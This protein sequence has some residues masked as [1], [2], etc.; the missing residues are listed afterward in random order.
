MQRAADLRSPGAG[1]RARAAARSA[2]DVHVALVRPGAAE[3]AACGTAALRGRPT[4]ASASGACSATR[5]SI[6]ARRVERDRRDRRARRVPTRAAAEVE[7]R[8]AGRDAC[9]ERGERRRDRPAPVHEPVVGA[10][11]VHID[12]AAVH[13]REEWQTWRFRG[14]D[15]RSSTTSRPRSRGSSRER[16]ARARSRCRAA[17]P[18][19]RAT[20]PLRAASRRLVG[21]RRVLR[22]RAVRAA[23]PSATRTRAWR[24]AC[25]STTCTPRA[26]HSMY[27]AGPIEDAAHA[28]DAL[29]RA[30]PPIDL[31]H[32][33]LGP[34]G[35]T[36][37]L[38]PG[39]P[40][41]RRD[42][43]LR[44]RDRR[45]RCTRTRV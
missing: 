16:G 36:A 31:V 6:A 15:P 22:R 38:F 26:I 25:C 44:R 27:Q 37:S 43:A 14:T 23:R 28:Y 30:A 7:A 8:R 34:D 29:V 1:R 39:T 32:L 10:L 42:R 19:R 24:A 45:R 41:A 5:S 2:G 3:R 12:G 35:H 17:R 21:R 18:P 13:D 4:T 11:L 20:R 9:R 40:G 33:G